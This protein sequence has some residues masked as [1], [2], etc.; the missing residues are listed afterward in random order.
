DENDFWSDG[1]RNQIRQKNW[2]CY[3]DGD[4]EAI[5]AAVTGWYDGDGNELM[6]QEIVFALIPL[7]GDEYVL[8]VQLTVHPGSSREK[9]SVGKTNFGFLAVRVAKSISEHFGGGKLSSS[10]GG[11]SE[12][13]IF[14]KQ[15]R[16]VDYSGPVA[17]GSGQS[18]ITVTEGITYFDHPDNPRYPTYWHVRADGWM[19]AS[20]GM[21]EGLVITREQPLTL[22]YLL[23]AHRGS[24]SHENAARQAQ[25]FAQRSRFVVQ[26]SS[27]S[28]EQF[29]VR[30]S[31]RP[32]GNVERNEN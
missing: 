11:V 6:E 1:A 31:P 30:R 5:M 7:V 15:A 16:W 32:N 10:E 3:R 14:G 25:A 4:D 13:E 12:K 26:E 8:E 29:E 27:K 18:R 28:H 22:R 19:G 21:H 2:Q 9:V 24:H 20:F 17:I 23:Y